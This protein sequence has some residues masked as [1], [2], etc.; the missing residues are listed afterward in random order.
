MLL[1]YKAHIQ[2][3]SQT[4]S[5]T[6]LKISSWNKHGNFPPPRPSGTKCSGS[7][8]RKHQTKIQEF[9]LRRGSSEGVRSSTHDRGYAPLPTR[10]LTFLF[11]PSVVHR[12]ISFFNLG[13]IMVN[14]TCADLLC[15]HFY[16]GWRSEGY[17]FC[18]LHIFSLLIFRTTLSGMYVFNLYLASVIIGTQKESP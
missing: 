6:I 1:K 11:R 8:M 16:W 17:I 7:G 15:T 13:E 18:L 2:I 3:K 14:F 12:N 5:K 4:Q 10:G 9:R